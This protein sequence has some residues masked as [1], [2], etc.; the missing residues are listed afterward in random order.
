PPA[1]GLWGLPGGP[2]EFAETVL[3]AAAR[4]LFEETAVRAEA[5]RAFQTV[6]AFDIA[7]DG[8]VRH[9]HVLVAVAC[10]WIAGEPVAGDDA[11]EAG[12]FRLDRLETE[13]EGLI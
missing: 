1:L 6:D 11:A 3:A 7:E 13:P 4:E 10:R 12:W 2:L 8:T 9:H 5:V